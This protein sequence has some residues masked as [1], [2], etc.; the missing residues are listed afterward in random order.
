MKLPY[1]EMDAGICLDH[2]RHQ[3][4][5]FFFFSAVVII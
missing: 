2:Y 4:Q 5:L 1:G 3:Q